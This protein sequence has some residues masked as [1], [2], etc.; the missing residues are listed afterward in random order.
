MHSDIGRVLISFSL[1]FPFP[2]IFGGNAVTIVPF[3]QCGSFLRDV[4]APPPDREDG[5]L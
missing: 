3:G 4:D 2:K 1:P 5:S